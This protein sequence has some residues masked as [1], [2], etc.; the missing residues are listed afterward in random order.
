MMTMPTTMA[1]GVAI[2][3]LAAMHL[4]LTIGAAVAHAFGDRHGDPAYHQCAARQCRKY[5][6][7]AHDLA[8]RPY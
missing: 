3:V 1:P 6:F 5:E 2:V 7:L 4:R 8:P